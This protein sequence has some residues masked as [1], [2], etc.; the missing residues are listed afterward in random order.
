MVLRAARKV[1]KSQEILLKVEESQEKS[2]IFIIQENFVVPNCR[3]ISMSKFKAQTRS[4]QCIHAICNSKI[5]FHKIGM[6]FNH[7]E[8]E[9]L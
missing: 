7:S 1:M 3:V 9:S 6:Q 8:C 5:P 4:L 2:G